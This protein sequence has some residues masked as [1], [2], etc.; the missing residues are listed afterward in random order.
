M[1]KK[2]TGITTVEVILVVLM[3]A[4][5]VFVG[6]TWYKASSGDSSMEPPI[7]GDATD[8]KDTPTKSDE[9]LE[10]NVS[11][12]MYGKVLLRTGNCMPGP[13][14][15]DQEREN[16][17]EANPIETTVYVREPTPRDNMESRY[18]AEETSLIKQ[19][20][21]DKEG[22]YEVELAPGTYSVFVEDDG[23]EYCSLNDGQGRMCP[24]KVGNG[25]TRH[26]VEIDHAAW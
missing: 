25:T 21:T 16:D 5:A 23:K 14:L 9:E 12:G 10:V 17:C 22:F 1:L 6:W 20:G 2:Q 19:V 26:D 8:E 11:Q 4:A 7:I 15:G 3:L 13:G 18:L 24:V